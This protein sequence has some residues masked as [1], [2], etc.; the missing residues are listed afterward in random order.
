NSTNPVQ[1]KPRIFSRNMCDPQELQSPGRYVQ[2]RTETRIEPSRPRRSFTS[3][4]STQDGLQQMPL[5][6]ARTPPQSSS[7]NFFQISV[8]FCNPP[9]LKSHCMRCT[10]MVLLN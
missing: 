8:F 5:S 7:P 6:N 9:R 3:L 10:R 1:R 2:H 4:T